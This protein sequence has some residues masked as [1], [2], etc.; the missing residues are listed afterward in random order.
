M[1]IR[2]FIVAVVLACAS[3]GAPSSSSPDLSPSSSCRDSTE[4]CAVTADCC[5][6]LICTANRCAVPPPMCRSLNETCGAASGACCDA[7]SCTGGKCANPPMCRSSG[8]SCSRTTPCCAPLGC[9]VDVLCSSCST[10][11]KACATSNDCC[12]GLACYRYVAACRA[13]TNLKLGEPCRNDNECVSGVCNQWCTRAC[14]NNAGCTDATYCVPTNIG[15]FC[16]PY[17]GGTTKCSVYGP[18]TTCQSAPDING[19][20][21][22]VC[23][24]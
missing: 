12:L 17:C 8:Q 11:S 15:D 3:C 16:V 23:L 5:G 2:G 14:L 21:V 20:N 22:L 6:E 4:A 1:E 9:S 24:G 7:L 19:T 18:G 13:A 10:T